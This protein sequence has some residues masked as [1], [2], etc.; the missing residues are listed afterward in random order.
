[1]KPTTRKSWLSVAGATLLMAALTACSPTIPKIDTLKI[2]KE[3]D[4]EKEVT[5]E[6]ASF[7]PK[8]TV[9]GFVKA[10]APGKVILKWQVFAVKVE[11]EDENA[12][13]SSADADV[14]LPG[15]GTSNYH[16]G[17]ASGLPLGKY[18][19]EVHMVDETGAEKDKKAV[20][21]TVA[22]S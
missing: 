2:G 22:G 13:V 7:V 5:K 15:S 20:E 10:S 12:H 21:F 18:R 3:I 19:L 8:D 6:T 17:S 9:Y 11:G 14:E 16:L 1:M 4:A